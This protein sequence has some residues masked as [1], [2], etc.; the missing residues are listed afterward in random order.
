MVRKFSIVIPEELNR[1]ID[2]IRDRL[3]HVLGR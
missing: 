1:E 3:D 2:Q